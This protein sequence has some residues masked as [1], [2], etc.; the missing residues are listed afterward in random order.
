MAEYEILYADLAL[1][2]I[3]GRIPFT[4][5]SISRALNG[6]G[7]FDVKLPLNTSVDVVAPNGDRAGIDQLDLD[8]LTPAKTAALIFRDNQLIYCGIIWAADARVDQNQLSLSGSGV[9]SY[10][11]R[12]HISTTLNYD[13]VDQADIAASL[14]N[15]GGAPHSFIYAD[16][17]YTHGVARDRTYID[18]ERKN[19]GEALVQLS[20]V[21]GGFDFE[22]VPERSDSTFTNRLVLHYP[23]YGRPTDYLL[24]VGVNCSLESYAI[25]GADIA[26]LVEILGSGVNDDSPMLSSLAS[27]GSS[28]PRLEFVETMSDVRT[29]STLQAHARRALALRERAGERLTLRLQGPSAPEVGGFQ[30]GDI[31]R[32]RGAYGAIN[33]DDDYRSVADKL[34]VGEDG[35]EQVSLEMLP[36]RMFL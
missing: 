16:G 21:S 26:N 30:V 5:F 28:Y 6:P 13:S 31:M 2:T 1:A 36:A 29:E 32:V 19:V 9:G 27:G 22:F 3:G 24:Q 34:T 12:R 20:E 18:L 4:D 25:A 23:A 17:S 14:V 8:D 11:H 33:V 15:F 35:T 7:S 10:L